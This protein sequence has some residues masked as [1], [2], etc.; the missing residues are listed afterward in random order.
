MVFERAIR[1]VMIDDVVAPVGDVVVWMVAAAAAGVGL[2]LSPLGVFL[3]L[4]P[5][6]LEPYFHLPFG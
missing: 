2:L 1:T 4:H 6:I 5:P 3:V